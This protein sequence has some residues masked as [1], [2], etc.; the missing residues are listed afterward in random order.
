MTYLIFIRCFYLFPSKKTINYFNSNSKIFFK[1]KT[2][3]KKIK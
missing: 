3:T 2:K 1:T